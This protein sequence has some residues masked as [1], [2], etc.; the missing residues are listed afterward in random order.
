MHRAEIVAITD[1]ARLREISRPKPAMRLARAAIE[2]VSAK[3]EQR[4]SN[5]GNSLAIPPKTQA[6]QGQNY[7]FTVCVNLVM[8]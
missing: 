7:R 8:F 4:L 5:L 6:N 1:Q 2:K 3:Q